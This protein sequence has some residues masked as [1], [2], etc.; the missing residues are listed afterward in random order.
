MGVF[1]AAWQLGTI[2]PHRMSVLP[3]LWSVP[4][5]TLLF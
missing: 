1:G 3:V 4:P 2:Y 5:L